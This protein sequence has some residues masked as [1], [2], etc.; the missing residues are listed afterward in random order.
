[1]TIEFMLGIAIGSYSL[2]SIL[3]GPHSS[4]PCPHW[5]HFLQLKLIFSRNKLKINIYYDGFIHIH[6]YKHVL[7]VQNDKSFQNLEGT[8]IKLIQ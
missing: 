5:M 2:G 1:M 4:K 8:T 3:D 6:I 7:V